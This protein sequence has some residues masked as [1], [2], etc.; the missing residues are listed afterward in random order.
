MAARPRPSVRAGLRGG[1][2]GGRG[3]EETE[4]GFGCGGDKAAGGGE[5]LQLQTPELRVQPLTSPRRAPKLASSL[6][7]T[8]AYLCTPLLAQIAVLVHV[9]RHFQALEAAR[10]AVA[11]SIPCQRCKRKLHMVDLPWKRFITG[12]KICFVLVRKGNTMFPSSAGQ[13]QSQH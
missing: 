9:R 5:R 11:R 10:T 3:N 1:A 7:N 2:G 4:R 12:P 6:N 8:S 13:E